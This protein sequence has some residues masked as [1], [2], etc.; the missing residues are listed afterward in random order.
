M[1]LRYSPEAS[2]QLD[3]LELGPDEELWNAVCAAIDLLVDR[4]DSPEA[5]RE[6]LLTA[7]GNTVWRV[8]V[9]HSTMDD[10]CVLW[11]LRSDV[12]YVLFVGPM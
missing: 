4:P 9:R 11:A 7:G 12:E 3:K 6:A 10:Y 1:P 2:A 8:P 5:R